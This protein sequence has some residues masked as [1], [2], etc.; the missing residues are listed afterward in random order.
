MTPP[1]ARVP[2]VRPGF[3]KWSIVAFLLL[4]PLVAYSIWDYVETRRLRTRIEAIAQQGAPTT[5]SA[6][7][8]LTG[9]STRAARY[10]QAAASLVSGYTAAIPAP[11]GYQL[12]VAARDGVWPQELVVRA[13]SLL[14]EHGEALSLADRAA[15]LPFDGFNAGTTFN[16]LTGNLVGVSRLC[17]L[18]ANVSALDGNADA[19]IASVFTDVKLARAT[20]QPPS[21]SALAFALKRTHPSSEALTQLADALAEIDRDDRFKQQLARMRAQMLDESFVFNRA[22]TGSRLWDLHRFNHSLDVFSQLIAAAD[23]PPLER[24]AAVMAVGEWPIWWSRTVTGRATLESLLRASERETEAIRCARRL[25][26]GEVVD[27]HF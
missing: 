24:H 14:E 22:G 16:Y 9:P 7:R 3:L 2:L 5:A 1:D 8:P 13:R 20:R 23:T 18:R 21:F 4:T 26:A 11:I 19:A 25:V 17:G 27:C 10:Y 12:G 6:Y 15:V